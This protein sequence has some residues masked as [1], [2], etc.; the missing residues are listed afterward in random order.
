MPFPAED[1]SY[2]LVEFSGIKA[3]KADGLLVFLASG[4]FDKRDAHVFIGFVEAEWLYPND[5]SGSAFGKVL[6][7]IFA[8]RGRAFCADNAS[9]IAERDV[10][11]T[12]VAVDLEPVIGSLHRG[13]SQGN[14][15]FLSHCLADDCDA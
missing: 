12:A 5:D 14:L 2:R 11:L 10:E 6:Q 1:L 4:V 7:D 3:V 15:N 8:N 13:I 9:V